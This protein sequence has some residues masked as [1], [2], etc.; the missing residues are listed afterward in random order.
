MSEREY[1]LGKDW[2]AM[3]DAA[4]AAVPEYR[5]VHWTQQDVILLQINSTGLLTR[6]LFYALLDEIESTYAVSIEPLGGGLGKFSAL[7][8][9]VARPLVDEFLAKLEP[10]RLDEPPKFRITDVAT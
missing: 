7:I 6:H 9:V 2:R 3:L 5:Y 1:P 8:P 10:H 4:H